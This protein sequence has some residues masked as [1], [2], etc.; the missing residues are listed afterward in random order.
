MLFR[1]GGK[2][3][4]QRT[5]LS[6]YACAGYFELYFRGGERRFGYTGA[7]PGRSFSLVALVVRS[8]KSL[9]CLVFAQLALHPLRSS[10]CVFHVPFALELASSA[11]RR[12]GGR[13][14]SEHHPGGCDGSEPFGIVTTGRPQALC[15]GDI[16][17]GLA[18]AFAS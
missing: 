14:C 16:V 13:V 17:A 6:W 4:P 11:G 8:E 15:L 7:S 5:G 12:G 1:P 10:V 2:K 3:K 18:Q 9:H